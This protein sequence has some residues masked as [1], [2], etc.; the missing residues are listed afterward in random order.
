MRENGRGKFS[1]ER[2]SAAASRS[3]PDRS[4][5]SFPHER[6]QPGSGLRL[7]GVLHGAGVSEGGAEIREGRKTQGIRVR[8]D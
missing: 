2:V 1:G 6:E 8:P 5:V 7:R 4:H 3:R